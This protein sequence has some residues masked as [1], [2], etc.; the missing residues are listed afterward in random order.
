METP[1]RDRDPGLGDH[2]TQ[3]GKEKPERGRPKPYF[4]EVQGLLK[5]SEG[6]ESPQD[7]KECLMGERLCLWQPYAAVCPKENAGGRGG[8]VT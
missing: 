8:S 6:Q 5:W 7:R 4:G 2:V 3:M 1:Q